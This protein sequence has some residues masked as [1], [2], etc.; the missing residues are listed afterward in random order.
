MCGIAGILAFRPPAVDRR[1]LQVMAQAIA[2]RGPDGEGIWIS[3]DGQVGFAHRRLAIIDVS[4][5]SDQPL[6]STDGRFT[7]VFNG[8]IYNFLELRAELEALGSLFRTQGDSEVI[9]EAW[10]HWGPGMLPRMN[11]MWA[12]A[13]H[14][15]EMRQTIF[16]R[17]R[18][19]VKPFYYAAADHR[20]AFAS[21][22]RAFY[23]LAWLDKAADVQVIRRTLFDVFG[24]EA[25]ERTL[26]KN[27]KRLPAGHYAICHD[28]AVQIHRWWRTCENLVEV[29]SSEAT[30][31][32]QFKALFLDSTQLR[33]R[34]D[35]PI[36]TCLSGGFDS[37]AIACA[38]SA[39]ARDGAA[40]PRETEDWRHA[41]VASFPGMGNDE[42]PQALE[43]AAYAGIKPNVLEFSDDQALQDIDQVLADLDDVYIMLPTA[44][45]QLYRSLRRKQICVSLDGHGADELMGGYR[46]A[47]VSLPY[48]IR[49]IANDLD[50]LLKPFSPMDAARS[51]VFSRSGMQ[52]LRGHDLVAPAQLPTSFDRDVLP[53]HWGPFDRRLYRMFHST[54]LPTILRNFDRMSMAHGVEVRMPFMDWRLVT[55]VMSL[56]EGDKS[57]DGLTKYIA[58]QAMAG[59]MPETIRT[60]RRKVGFASPM[61]E[62]MNGPL[63]PWIEDLFS[64]PNAAFD[65]I[66]NTKALMA[67]VRSLTRTGQ[68]TWRSAEHIWPYI[69]MRWLFGRVAT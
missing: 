2:H 23:N 47:G 54:L 57:R 15:A 25:G 30:R 12:F 34:S 42:T 52:F 63:I 49:N 14:D 20:L 40:H 1:D 32:D 39:I 50:G 6:H 67:R 26:F 62:W 43:A 8:E 53:S 41:F 9:I 64:R 56:G 18:F 51:V 36:G 17:D 11:G 60:S 48:H 38:I 35:V 45:W 13:L 61:V 22:M 44:V 19:G 33:M 24:V 66:V 4:R 31:V 27:V 29:S 3:R 7:L 69:H 46:Q 28:G 68:W 16:A 21:E 55:Y 5:N 37:T 58:R 59:L 65:E 10:R